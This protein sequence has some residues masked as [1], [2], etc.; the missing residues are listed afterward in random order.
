MGEH[1]PRAPARAGAARVV[2]AEDDT[3]LRVLIAS[4]LRAQGYEVVEIRDGT[5][6]LEYVA[7][8]VRA[9]GT[10]YDVDLLIS[11]I[12]MPGFTGLHVIAALRKVAGSTPVILITAFGDEHT[13]EYA[14]SLDVAAVLDKP[15]DLDRLAQQVESAL[16]A[17]A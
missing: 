14:K 9:D 8:H 6:L 5:E 12:R 16:T 17:T 1:H 4:V 13:H 15:F 11:D 10:L 2:L 7:D 3:E